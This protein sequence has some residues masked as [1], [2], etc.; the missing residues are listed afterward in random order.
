[1]VVVC[2]WCVREKCS[3]CGVL[4]VCERKVLWCVGGV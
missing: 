2:W 4:V 3:G 1:M